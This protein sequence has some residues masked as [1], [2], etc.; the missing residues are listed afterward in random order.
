MS[1]C[2]VLKEC[3]FY[4]GRYDQ[5]TWKRILIPECEM[6]QVSGGANGWRRVRSSSFRAW[7]IC[8]A[9]DSGLDSDG[10]TEVGL[11]ILGI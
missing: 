11:R 10:G 3:N 4:L 8:L 6:C 9:L 5:H 7:W 2:L 1:H